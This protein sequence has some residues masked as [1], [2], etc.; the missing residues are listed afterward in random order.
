LSF[1]IYENWLFSTYSEADTAARRLHKRR[2][3]VGLSSW[4]TGSTWSPMASRAV[5]PNIGWSPSSPK[6][7]GACPSYSPIR[8]KAPLPSLSI[9]CPLAKLNL[10]LQWGFIPKS[11]RIWRGIMEYM[12]PLSASRFTARHSAGFSG[13]CSD[14]STVVKPIPRLLYLIQIFFTQTKITQDSCQSSFRNIFAS[15]VRNGGISIPLGTPPDFMPALCLSP[16]LASQSPQLSGKFPIGH[17]ALTV[18]RS[19]P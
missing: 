1:Y 3:S 7:T 16:E 18:R 8:Y 13:L 12:A 14:T 6:M 17:G 11:S 5:T 19:S 4:L 9:F 15:V 2:S 10:R